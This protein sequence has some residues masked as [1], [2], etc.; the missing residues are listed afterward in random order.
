MSKKREPHLLLAAIPLAVMGVHGWWF[1]LVD[2]WRGE[3]LI[4]TSAISFCA[5]FAGIMYMF[6]ELDEGEQE[7]EKDEKR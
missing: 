6:S 5:V 1:V 4:N 7:G 3:W 2:G